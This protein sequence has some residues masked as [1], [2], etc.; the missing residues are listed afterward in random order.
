M[1]K[2]IALLSVVLG[3][4]VLMLISVAGVQY[5]TVD[6]VATD[7]S[8]GVACNK[9]Y[10]QKTCLKYPN[11]CVYNYNNKRCQYKFGISLPPACSSAKNATSCYNIYNNVGAH[12]CTWQNNMTG[13]S[14]CVSI[15][16]ADSLPTPTP[17]P[18]DAKLTINVELCTIDSCKNNLTVTKGTGVYLKWT[19]SSNA[20]RCDLSGT[21]SMSPLPSTTGLLYGETPKDRAIMWSYIVT[22]QGTNSE[23]ASDTSILTSS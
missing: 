22:C 16:I 2:S 10:K 9:I 12:L 18:T 14:E 11:D 7:A 4:V 21:H 19:S 17:T 23:K 8:G 5:L 3:V 15:D 1:T 6:Y 20:V 13:N